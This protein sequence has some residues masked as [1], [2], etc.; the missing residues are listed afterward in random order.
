MDFLPIFMDV[1]D[2]VCLIVGGGEVAARKVQMLLRAGA[3]VE[4]VAPELGSTME[5]LQQQG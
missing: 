1:R 2:R 4:V 3:K 5:D